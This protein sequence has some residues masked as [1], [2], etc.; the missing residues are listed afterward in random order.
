MALM[1]LLSFFL[2][3]L[4]M[5]TTNSPL[6]F[7]VPLSQKPIVEQWHASQ[8]HLA[9]HPAS[10]PVSNSTRSFWM[11]PSDTKS[12]NETYEEVNPFAKEGSVGKVTDEAD[13]CIVGSGISGVGVAYHLSKL[14]PEKKVVV[15]E[16][17][18]F[19]VYHLNLALGFTDSKILAGS[20]ATG[21]NGG[22]LT[23]AHFQD[24]QEHLSVMGPVEAKKQYYLEQHTA[25]S[26]VSIIESNDWVED[27]D[28]VNG[29]HIQMLV[30]KEEVEEARADYESAANAGLNIDAVKWI[31]KEEMYEVCSILFRILD[32]C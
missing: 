24:F 19:C 13:V 2:H 29:G 28:L 17:R 15:L 6:V 26:L 9:S 25:N 12:S 3:L 8:H 31:S 5:V 16:A 7:P 11:H 22:H 30:S 27:V 1:A 10:L 21:R 14:A 20:G 4:S 23:P 32:C 18:D